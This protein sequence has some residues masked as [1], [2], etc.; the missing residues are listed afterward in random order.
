MHTSYIY[1]ETG[2]Y[3][4]PPFIPESI[5]WRCRVGGVVVVVVVLVVAALADAG[6]LL[7]DW[8]CGEAT[9]QH[10]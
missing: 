9:H 1:Y 6:V 5:R 10:Y 4:E 2:S 3:K 8:Q 7:L